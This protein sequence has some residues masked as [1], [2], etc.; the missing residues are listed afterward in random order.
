MV[1]GKFN[2]LCERAIKTRREQD[3]LEKIQQSRPVTSLL[4]FSGSKTPDSK[5]NPRHF[6]D[7]SS[8]ASDFEAKS[9][10]KTRKKPVLEE[11]KTP[12]AKDSIEAVLKELE[13]SENKRK[14]KNLTSI[15]CFILNSLTEI[16]PSDVAF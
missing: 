15:V 4:E 2:E 3:F 6:N 1:I 14:M 8:S 7:F 10:P 11:K 12:E 16:R 9:K 13:T 5:Y